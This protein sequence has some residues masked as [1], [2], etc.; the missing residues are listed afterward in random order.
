MNTKQAR[1]LKV[2]DRVTWREPSGMVLTTHAA[3]VASGGEVIQKEYSGFKVRWDDGLECAYRFV[4]ADTIH[5][6]EAA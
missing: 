3:N 4:H 2:G 5:R 6:A 1:A